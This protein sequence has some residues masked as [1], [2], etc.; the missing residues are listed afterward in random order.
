MKTST[1]LPCALFGLMTV[2]FASATW[3][4]G[5]TIQPASDAVKP[6]PDVV[7]PRPDIVR[8]NPEVI[9]K[10]CLRRIAGNTKKIVRANRHTA[11]R[12][13][14]V[15]NKLQ[16]AGR[17]RVAKRHARTCMRRI[18]RRSDASIKRNDKICRKCV[19]ALLRLDASELARR[20]T[21]KCRISNQEISDSDDRAIAIIRKAM[22]EIKPSINPLL[23]G[24][25]TLRSINGQSP[26]GT[27]QMSLSFSKTNRVNGF[28]GV[29]QF[30][31]PVTWLGAESVRFGP[32]AMTKMA[33]PEP[34]M[35]Q[36][37][38]Y[39]TLLQEVDSVFVEM[40]LLQLLIGSDVVLEYSRHH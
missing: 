27:E 24:D 3:A 32:L 35:E 31:G 30:F 4:D 11:A 6:R 17:H 5:P 13:V 29:N 39:M 26:Q 22:A 9:A 15:V 37:H 20:V 1:M 21:V 36:E 16:A 28:S 40:D 34:L 10:R 14:V 8:P 19:K 38:S 33:G 18:S 7:K 25:W 2:V 23:L 12:C